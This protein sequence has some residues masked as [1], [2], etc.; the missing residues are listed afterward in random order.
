[1]AKIDP[2]KEWWWELSKTEKREIEAKQWQLCESG[3]AKGSDFPMKE[4][5]EEA[6]RLFK[7]KPNKP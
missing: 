2:K 7:L 6:V 3:F 4:C 5:W 1:M